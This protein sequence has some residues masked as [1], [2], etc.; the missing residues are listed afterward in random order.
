MVSYFKGYFIQKIIFLGQKYIF[1][2]VTYIEKLWTSDMWGGHSKCT[3]VMK[4]ENWEET[5]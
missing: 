1:C 5:V 4:R 2:G 3:A